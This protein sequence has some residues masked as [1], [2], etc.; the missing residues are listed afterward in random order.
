MIVLEREKKCN[1]SDKNVIND[2]KEKE[3]KYEE[4]REQEEDEEKIKRK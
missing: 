2:D 4:E 1:D 3:E